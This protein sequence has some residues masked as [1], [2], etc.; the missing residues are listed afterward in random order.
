MDSNSTVHANWWWNS[1]VCACVGG[2]S[3]DA[4]ISVTLTHV[5]V[6]VRLSKL[7]DKFVVYSNTNRMS[8]LRRPESQIWGL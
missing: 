5:C 6:G 2:T 8:R 7:G 3:I 1:T 4:A